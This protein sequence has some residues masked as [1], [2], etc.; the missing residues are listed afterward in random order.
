MNEVLHA[1]EL[2]S[3][4][5][6]AMPTMTVRARLTGSPANNHHRAPARSSLS[7]AAERDKR[8]RLSNATCAEPTR[9]KR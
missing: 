8:V 3:L 2:Q 4:S 6:C 1:V 7:A 5:G 9:R